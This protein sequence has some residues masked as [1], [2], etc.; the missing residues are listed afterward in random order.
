MPSL[1]AVSSRKLP[2]PAAQTLF[3]L[4]STTNPSLRDV[5]LASCPPNSKIVS[6]PG[7]KNV[8]PLA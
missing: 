8:V 5:Y 2:V 6:I 3:I 4:K 1:F 7:A